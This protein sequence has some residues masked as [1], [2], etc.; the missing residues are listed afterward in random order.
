MNRYFYESFGIELVQLTNAD[1]S[2]L[3]SE[4]EMR[5]SFF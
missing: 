4:R 5:L 2:F 1:D 3:F